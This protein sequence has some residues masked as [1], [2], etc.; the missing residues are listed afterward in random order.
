MLR[1]CLQANSFQDGSAL[2]IATYH[3]AC[4][5]TVD[6]TRSFFHS[7]N[8]TFE[9]AA[10]CAILTNTTHLA[11]EEAIKEVQIDLGSYRPDA[12]GDEGT[13]QLKRRD[14]APRQDSTVDLTQD[15]SAA[16][17][18][19]NIVLD[20]SQITTGPDPNQPID[21][22]G[23]LEKRLFWPLNVVVDAVV[24]VA[25]KVVQ[26]FEFG[27]Q[28][29]ESLFNK[30]KEGAVAVGDFISEGFHHEFTPSYQNKWPFEVGSLDTTA[31][32]VTKPSTAL[33]GLGEG[34]SLGDF[35]GDV[36]IQCIGCGATGALG[37]DMSIGFSIA[38]GLKSGHLQLN[39]DPLS[40]GLQFGITVD[41]VASHTFS[42]QIFSAPLSPLGIP[43]I[44]VL[45][46]EVSMN[47]ALNVALTGS[48]Q[49]L[50]GGLLQVEAGD[51]TFDLTNGANNGFHGFTP[52]F[53]PVA[54]AN[55]SIT[56]TVDLGLPLNLEFGIDIFNGKLK[57]TVA[58]V[59]HPSI[60]GSVSASTNGDC[61]G[62]DFSVGLSNRIYVGFPSTVKNWGSYELRT[63]KLPYPLG[64]VE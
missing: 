52:T 62:L 49:I 55:G 7:I 59:E 32:S 12:P 4:G 28:Q 37:V 51:F 3:H 38:D 23:N 54:M 29:V 25:K 42:S 63:D 36:T 31:T 56:A 45:G 18:F 19:F 13:G 26:V 33:F 22:S 27:A 48:A 41:V 10:M 64:C 61:Q 6:G 2:I 5:N 47:A 39:S 1:D 8:A 21:E 34:L 53:T 11:H 16:E 30:I 9:D 14:M 58:L 17:Y 44:I 40:I 60:Y 20:P 57:Q 46:P 15:I 50:I 24:Y 43:N 35:G